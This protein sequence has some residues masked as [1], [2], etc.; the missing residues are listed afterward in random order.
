MTD[1]VPRIQALRFAREARDSIDA[2]LVDPTM[3]C[4]CCFTLA[5]NLEIFRKDL[6]DFLRER[7]F[8]LFFQ[9]PWTSGSHMLEI[10]ET[11]CYYSMRLCSYK[12]FFA[13]VLHLYNFLTAL[14]QM[15]GIP[16][17]EA[18]CD[19]FGDIVFPG[20]RPKA[21]FC[22]QF[23]RL[24]G[25]RLKQ[26]HLDRSVWHLAV[27]SSNAR[28]AAGFGAPRES[29]D[30]RFR[31]EKTSLLHLIKTKGYQI[32]KVTWQSMQAKS[33]SLSADRDGCKA[34]Y[35]L[36]K[37][38]SSDAH[39]RTSCYWDHEHAECA[40][41]MRAPHHLLDLQDAIAKSEL[42]QSESNPLPIDCINYFKLY[43]IST[44][45]VFHVSTGIHNE[46]PGG[47]YCICFIEELLRRGDT[48]LAHGR[49][50]REEHFGYKAMVN[51]CKAGFLN[52]F[53][54]DEEEWKQY[55]WEHM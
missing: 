43:L 22:T 32:D 25:G 38:P 31:Y 45:F 48:L 17:L 44:R 33:K 19:T 11:S 47:S 2:G 15:D 9:S 40:L 49:A 34:G 8:D 26:S 3:P 39:A 4:R 18:L 5:S 28:E 51:L 52:E 7:S 29:I 14:G 36:D 53:R 12:H 20:G 46:Q 23:R 21:G 54:L 24:K 10:L 55:L 27:P 6:D 1:V 13:S 42:V 50:Y 16:F 41:R 37:K 35:D 30:S